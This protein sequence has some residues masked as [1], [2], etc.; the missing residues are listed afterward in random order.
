MALGELEDALHGARLAYADMVQVSTSAAP[1][2]DATNRVL[3]DRAL[4]GRGV[5]RVVDRALDVGGGASYFRRA[6]LERLFRDAQASRYHPVPDALQRELA[7]K[8]AL[9]IPWDA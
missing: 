2:P 7:G 9:G 6:G 4:V 3:M 8:S 5:R 1:G